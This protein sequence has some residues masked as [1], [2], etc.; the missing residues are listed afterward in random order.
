MKRTKLL[1]MIMAMLMIITCLVSPAMANP[2]DAQTD[3]LV[4][5]KLN[6]L[7]PVLTTNEEVTIMVKLEGD[8]TFMQTSDLQLATASYDSQMAAMAQ[9]E[10]RIE[11]ALSQ[12][13]EVE[14]RF[15]LLFNGFSF[16]GESW[17]VDEINALPGVSAFIAPMFELIEAQTV[18]DVNL[19]P[20]MA[21][22]TN[23][24]G[25]NYVWDMGYTGEGMVVAILDTGISQ[26]H[27]GFT[28]IPENI[29]MDKAYVENVY[30]TYGDKMHGGSLED[31]DGI[32]YNDKMPFNWDY[33]DG[34][35]I[36]NHT[37]STHGSHVAGIVAGNNGK[38]FK[39]VAPDAQI[40]TMQ[41]FNTSGGASFATLMEAMED[42]VYLG[43]DAINMSLGITAYFVGYDTISPDMEGLYE[44]LENAGIAICAAAGND[45]SSNYETNISKGYTGRWFSWNMDSGA[46]GAPAVYPGSFAVASVANGFSNG[47]LTAYGEEYY[48]SSVFGIT[49]LASLEDKS[50]DLVYVGLGS[51]EEI[52][53]AGNLEGKIA[54]VKRGILDFEV[55]A[56]NV[57]EAGAVA[58]LIFNNETSL[59]N[60]GFNSTI[61]VGMMTKLEG[62]RLLSKLSDGVHGEV[63]VHTDM[64]FKGVSM[65][66]TS[67]WGT[68]ASLD[69]KPEIAAPGDNINSV[70]G[71]T[72]N[73]TMYGL[74]SGTSMAT[75]HVAGGMLLVKQRLRD[76]F[77]D[78]SVTEINELA[79]TFLMSTAH[80]TASDVRRA[81]AGLMDVASAVTTEAYLTVPGA[82]RPKLELRD[83][84]EGEFT[85]TFE[86][87]NFG[88]EAKTYDIVPSVLVEIAEELEYK[89]Y[90]EH[91]DNAQA[92]I[93]YNA[94]NDF[95]LSNPTYTTVNVVSGCVQ[96][97]TDWCTIAGPK[98]VTVEAGETETIL[99]TIKTD[100]E[101]MNYIEE[102]F[103][104]GTYLEGY[105]ALEDRAANGNDL[106]IPFL[107]FIG[108]WDYIPMLDS[109]FWWN[110]PYG[111]N[112]L[113]QMPTTW[114]TY[115]GYGL[116]GQGLGLNYYWDATGETYVADRNAISPN[117]DGW[118]DAVDII[119]F[120]LMRT[121][122]TVKL[123][124]QDAEGNVLKT[125]EDHTYAFRKELYDA[126][127]GTSY[128]KFDFSFTAEDMEENETAYLVLEAWLDRE[129]FDINDNMNGRLVF[130]VTKDTVAP[131]VT[132]IHNGIQILDDNYIAYYAVYADAQ[133]NEMLFEDG[134]FTEE[135]GV[136]ETYA[137]ELDTYFVSVADYAH[138]EAFYMVM[139]GQ[140]YAMDCSGFD[141]VGKTM[142]GRE[143]VNW[144]TSLDLGVAT[145]E[146]GW[147]TFNTD[148]PNTLNQKS[149]LLTLEN[150]PYVTN[151][152]T[153]FSSGVLAD[154][155]TAYVC[156]LNKLYTL[157]LDTYEVTEIAPFTMEGYAAPIVR[158]MTKHPA[159][160]EV[161][162]WVD[163]SY[164]NPG[165]CKI[166][167]ETGELTLEWMLDTSLGFWG[168][169]FNVGACFIDANTVAVWTEMDGHKLWL[170]D[171]ETGLVREETASFDLITPAYGGTGSHVCSVSTTSGGNSM[172]YD[173]E[174]NC[175]YM[176]HESSN[177]H[178]NRTNSGGFIKYD[179][180]T[181]TATTYTTGPANGYYIYGLFFLEDEADDCVYYRQ[182]IAPTCDTEGYTLHTCADCGHEYRDNFV[183]AL[184]HTYEGIVTEPTCTDMG[185]T[186]YTCTVCGDSYVADYT[187]PVD[188]VF[189]EVVIEPTC[190]EAGY[191]IY[192]CEC[193]HEEIGD[194]VDPI[195][196]NY[197]EYVVEPTCEDYGYTMYVCAVCGDSFISGYTAPV[198]PAEKFTDVD[199]SQ[200]YHEGI[201]Y[202]IRNGLMNG[203]SETVFA[204]TANLTRAELV[205]VLYRMA[206]SPSVEDLE[207]PFADVADDTWYTDAVIWAYNAE[208]VKGISNTAFAPNANITREQIATILYRYAGA[209]EVEEDALADFADADKVNAYAVDAMNWAVSVDLINGMDDATLAPQ[210]NATRA[211]IATILMRY[212][213]G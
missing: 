153:D 39:G 58:C 156:S 53:A 180:D 178:L 74:M 81:G 80:Q 86:V 113:A 77:P 114:G 75:P 120:S 123:Y 198:C 189:V 193:G 34:D 63:T 154:D 164:M 195:G 61:P 32:Y 122:K 186:T 14:S 213:E 151:M 124:L 29:K 108:D 57:A 145:Y 91:G 5:M 133:R 79:H 143:F 44:A 165:F 84:E 212:C 10:N 207:H 142:V 131:A 64:G 196:H 208:V 141:K 37:S 54:L 128:S 78:K 65:A 146:Y 68:T 52:A 104:S 147:Y 92:F 40:V 82:D 138:N 160:G 67:S 30:K 161:Y 118:L 201:C 55:K 166:N 170:T 105:I 90:G 16:T 24:V 42:C 94:R 115:L 110:L 6:G 199:T 45:A 85:F 119:E 87:N 206:G 167:L 144:N 121:P 140:V 211:Q 28:A 202:V 99:M 204:P 135:R 50:Y 111:V 192:M 73:N 129:G 22:S 1:S 210:G 9:A 177:Y 7:E 185:Y 59:I 149:E 132:A 26:T 117:G 188:H 197:E 11:K 139:D 70:L 182:D 8:T 191:T 95:L 187:K 127:W 89:G 102:K 205:T 103:P 62:E 159:T 174:E 130:P 183:P 209:E 157:N 184:G 12:S 126:T 100:S 125:Y 43:V 35:H 158:S 150:N 4:E 47:Y 171:F 179:L 38:D 155:G 27:D 13:I 109:G 3:E 176:F 116:K 83:N 41:V 76:L 194:V 31:L 51:P 107:G 200:W 168:R 25:A 203:K 36:P 163:V 49:T 96:D 88:K 46:I 162:G 137:T 48:P 175:L 19:S 60:V 172:V 148:T 23:L 69:I 66:V 173:A 20:A 101:L 106:S 17:M 136:A 97:V 33:F 71:Y 18:E 134:V 21:T 98:A 72:W 56:K 15:S 152:G 169:L 181:R 190:T 2:A 112:N 93:E